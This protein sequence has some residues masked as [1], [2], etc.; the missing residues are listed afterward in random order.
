MPDSDKSFDRTLET[1]LNAIAAAKNAISTTTG[2]W[3]DSTGEAS[4]KGSERIAWFN[5]ITDFV[6][7]GLDL[8]NELA[9]GVT[10]PEAATFS[11]T[12]LNALIASDEL[13]FLKDNNGATFDALATALDS[14]SSCS[15]FLDVVIKDSNTRNLTRIGE[16]SLRVYEQYAVHS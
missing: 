15:T 7:R 13:Q 9:D 5:G 14:L 2:T 8:I 12:A 16:S 10:V 1:E 3:Y 6:N 11:L 4:T